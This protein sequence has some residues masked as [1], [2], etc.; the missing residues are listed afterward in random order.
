MESSG[1]IVCKVK[2]GRYIGSAG[3]QMGTGVALTKQWAVIP[4]VESEI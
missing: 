4:S 2:S 1:N 3:G